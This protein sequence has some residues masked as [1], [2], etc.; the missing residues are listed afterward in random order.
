VEFRRGDEKR[1]GPLTDSTVDWLSMIFQLAHMP[2][3]GESMDLRVYTQRRLYQYQLQVLGMEQ[4]E[5]P[6]GR[7][8]ALHLRHTGEKPEET[9]D[10]W[11]GAE[12]HF[13]PV[14]L[15]YPVARNR[16]IVEQTATSV[17]ER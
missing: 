13:L 4:L 6:L 2:P 10:V 11:L 15:R 3:K 17:R 14:K 8:N 5:L 16:L 9:V 1:T 7:T 12:H